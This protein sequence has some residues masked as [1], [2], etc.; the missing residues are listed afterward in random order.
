LDTAPVIY[1]VERHPKYGSVVD[2]IFDGI[3][4]GRLLVV[5]SPITLSECLVVPCQLGDVSAQQNFADLIVRGQGVVF[6]VID[7]GIAR[8]AAALR[9]R[10]NLSL[11][12]AFQL[13][14]ALVAGC[15]GLL[16]NDATL[17][18]V[19]EIVVIVVDELQP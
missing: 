4:D 9:A 11:T 14:T 19:Q 16:T 15:D 10:Y 13:A 2:V 1:Y 12:D 6:T 5:T 18:R 8:Q 17:K 3:D 7:E